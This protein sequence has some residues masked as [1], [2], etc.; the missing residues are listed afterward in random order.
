MLQDEHGGEYS[1]NPNAISSVTNLG[2]YDMCEN[3][4]T[5]IDMINGGVHFTPTAYNK[6]MTAI[7][8]ANKTE[9][10]INL[11]YSLKVLMQI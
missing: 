2:P 10:N 11:V 8:K 4:A 3:K 7:E 9:A 5:R 1:I 6:L